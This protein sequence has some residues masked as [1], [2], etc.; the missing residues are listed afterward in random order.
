MALIDLRVQ[1]GGRYRIAIDPAAQGCRKADPMY[2]IIPCK[3]GEIYALGGEYLA[4]LVD[5]PK[6]GNRLRAVPELIVHQVAADVIVFGFHIRDFEKITKLAGAR[7]KRQVK[8]EIMREIGLGTAYR[9]RIQGENERS[10]A[11]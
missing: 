10:M 1:F 9:A 7:R 6:T 3:I 5:K 8:S 11:G 2:W 4:L